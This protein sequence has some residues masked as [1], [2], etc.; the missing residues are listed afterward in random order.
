[1]IIE[2]PERPKQRSHGQPEAKIQ[3]DSFRWFW[4]QYPQYRGL[5]FAVTNQNERSGDISKKAQLISGAMRKNLGLVAGVSDLI[6]LIPRNGFHGLCLECKT[7]DGRQKPPQEWWQGIV[8]SQGYLYK[9]FR[10]KEEFQQIIEWYL[11]LK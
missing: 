2:T 7:K 10:S 4:G 3:A 11:N 8:E 9:I 6:M 1:M 5:L